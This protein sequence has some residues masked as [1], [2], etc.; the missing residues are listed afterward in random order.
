DAPVASQDGCTLTLAPQGSVTC[1]ISVTEIGQGART[2]A[3][4]IVASV[5]GVG[6]EDVTINLGDSGITPYG[7][8]NW[9]SRGAGIGGEAAYQAA[10]ALRKNILQVAAFLL[11]NEPSCLDI[12]DRQIVEF[13]TGAIRMSLKEL[14][15]KVY[16]RTELFPKNFQPELVATRHVAQKDFDGIVTNGIQGVYL[17]VD[18]E[19]GFLRLLKHWVVHDCGTAINPDLVGEQIRGGVAQGLGAALGE[20]CLYS[21]E[22]QLLNGSLAE[23]LVPMAVEMP[24]MDIDL[25]STPTKSSALGAK[26]AAEAGTAGAPAAV[27]NAINDALAPFEV[28]LS[29]QPFTPERILRALGMPP[30]E[31]NRS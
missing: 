30:R 22:G 15:H 17:E 26:G 21:P 24:D 19:T 27:M 12:R 3:G 11:Q 4:Q 31:A 6:M 25:I 9:G 14:A 23:Y 28:A 10:Q 2:I 16:F 8:G 7:G 20:A 18:T 5:L 1:A 13:G 29:V